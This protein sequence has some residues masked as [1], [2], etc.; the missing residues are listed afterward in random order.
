MADTS[1]KLHD[2]GCYEISLGDTIGIGNP[3]QATAVIRRVKEHIP[4]EMLAA[5]FHD[6]YGQALVNLLAVLQEGVAVIDSAVAG[7]GGCPFAR[8][9]TGNVATEDVLY[10]LEGLGVDTGV[11]LHRVATAGHFI[12]E[13]LGRNTNSR[14]AYNIARKTG[15]IKV[16]MAYR[17]M[18]AA[19]LLDGVLSVEEIH[20]LRQYR[21]RHNI[22]VSEHIS[23]LEDL[24]WTEADFQ[25]HGAGLR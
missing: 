18:V 15:E 6:T 10:M 25:K 23:A 2:M 1:M 14:V 19:T 11:D 4:V 17:D 22:S 8:G 7:L 21:L 20:M 16:P 3:G 12:S 9:A 5:H 24:G 13:K